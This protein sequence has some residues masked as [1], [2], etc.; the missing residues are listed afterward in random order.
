MAPSRT[1]GADGAVVELDELAGNRKSEAEAGMLAGVRAIL[2]PEL[3]EHVRQ[4]GR[5]DP[6]AGVRNFD[7]GMRA[8]ESRRQADGS[9]FGG[10]LQCVRDDVPEDL[11]QPV[12]V[13]L[14]D[15]GGSEL[16]VDDDPLCLCRDGKTLGNLRQQDV[17]RKGPPFEE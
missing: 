14:H 9:A 7:D 2:L 17:D 16:T 4:E 10:E 5:R 13:P 6:D 8:V 15:R 1:G 12:L 3:V 11:A